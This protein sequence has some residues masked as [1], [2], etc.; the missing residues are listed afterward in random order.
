MTTVKKPNSVP[1]V[2]GNIEED[3]YEIGELIEICY[4]EMMKVTGVPKDCINT[5]G[6]SVSGTCATLTKLI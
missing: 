5:S 2:D 4:Q 1:S 3:A 6:A